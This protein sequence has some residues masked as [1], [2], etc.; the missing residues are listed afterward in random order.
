MDRRRRSGQV[1][2]TANPAGEPRMALSIKLKPGERL[3]VNGGVLRNS[4]K[5]TIALDVLNKVTLLQERDL[6]L[7]EQADTPL[8]TLYFL[9]QMMHLEPENHEAHFRPFVELGAQ[10]YA[11]EMQRGDSAMCDLVSEVIGLVGKR[12]F[13]HAMRRLQK[14]LGKPGANRNSVKFE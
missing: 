6:M 3:I 11:R 8:R 2:A 4:G 14:E 7:P 5:S 1:R 12:D 9:V 10:L 13:P